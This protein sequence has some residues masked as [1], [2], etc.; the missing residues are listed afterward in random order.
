MKHHFGVSAC[1]V[2]ANFSWWH[3]QMEA[4][5][6]LLAICAEN[7]PVTGEFPAQRP[8]TRSLNVFFDLRL[9][10]RL[11]KQWRGWWFETPSRPLWR[12]CNVVCVCVMFGAVDYSSY[13]SVIWQWGEYLFINICVAC[14]EG[15]I[16]I[17]AS[18]M[19]KVKY[20]RRHYNA[21][22]N[23]QAPLVLVQVHITKSHRRDFRQFRL[24][25]GCGVKLYIALQTLGVARRQQKLADH[26]L[27]SVLLF[28]L[29][30]TLPLCDTS[31]N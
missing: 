14:A 31:S 21:S 10:K 18:Y 9:N 24:E 8:V 2:T 1:I 27:S 25:S 11:S 15:A 6:A 17:Q 13:L 4:S 23:K 22:V 7:S 12:H 29:L 26:L 30:C 5:S 16:T 19:L 20:S 28:H 3:H